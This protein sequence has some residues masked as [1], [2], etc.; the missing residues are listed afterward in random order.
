MQNKEVQLT[1]TAKAITK[2]VVLDEGNR[3]GRSWNC[4][5]NAGINKGDTIVY[6]A[7]ILLTGTEKKLETF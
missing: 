1:T 2:T 5:W 4:A 7:P 3:I 6:N